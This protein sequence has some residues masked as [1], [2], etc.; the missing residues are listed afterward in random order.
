MNYLIGFLACLI[1]LLL[2]VWLT[3]LFF[4]LI[5][6]HLFYYILSSIFDY[7]LP[8]ISTKQSFAILLAVTVID[9]LFMRVWFV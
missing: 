5:W 2:V 6:N 8:L 9:L 7:D 4:K 1:A 3:V